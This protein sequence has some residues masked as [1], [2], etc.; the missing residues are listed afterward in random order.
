M[1]TDPG[2]QTPVTV[3][4]TNQPASYYANIF[5]SK[6]GTAA[7]QAYT[8]FDAAN[9]GNSPYINAKLFAVKVAVEGLDKAVADEAGL[10]GDVVTKGI[11]AAAAAV[12]KSPLGGIAAIGDFFG[13]LT[14]ANTWIRVA[15]FVLGAALIIVGLAKLASGTAAGKAALKV[16][17][18]A[19]IL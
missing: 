2:G 19:A 5:A 3:P 16:G 18:A 1:P 10:L 14:E 13:R 4:A 15:E 6:W 11:P 8:A 7:A 12:P 17:K 9:P